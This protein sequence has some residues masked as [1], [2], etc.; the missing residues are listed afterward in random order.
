MERMLDRK[1]F[2]GDS[3][4]RSYQISLDDE[5]EIIRTG[6]EYENEFDEEDD[7]SDTLDMLEDGMNQLRLIDG[8]WYETCPGRGVVVR[9]KAYNVR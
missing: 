3:T 2:L 4:G 1:E 7:I 6:Y 8:Q 5:R 9:R